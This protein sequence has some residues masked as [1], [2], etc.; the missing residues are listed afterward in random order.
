[1]GVNSFSLFSQSMEM[2]DY[3]YSKGV[4]HLAQTTHPA[5]VYM[6][7]EYTM[8]SKYV[9]VSIKSIDNVFGAKINTD[10]RII[11]GLGDLYFSNLIVLGD[12][13]LVKPFEAFG[14]Q[15]SF[16]VA[17]LKAIDQNTFLEVANTINQSFNTDIE[18]W[19]GKMWALLALNLD[20]YDYL[21]KK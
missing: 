19:N 14:L 12:N 17:V 9:D 8:D 2:E 15:S 1:L 11:R 16:L 18:H 13:D 7:G 6:S 5:N 4:F 3:F 20:Y 21:I 10:I